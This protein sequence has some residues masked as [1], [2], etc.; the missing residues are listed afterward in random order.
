MPFSTLSGITRGKLIVRLKIIRKKMAHT[1]QNKRLGLVTTT[2]ILALGG[3]SNASANPI[4]I[5]DQ[6]TNGAFTGA[7]LAGWTTTGSANARFA[8]NSINSAPPNGGGNTA[9]DNFFPNAFAVLGENTGFITGAPNQGISSLSQTFILPSI[10]GGPP[11]PTTDCELSTGQRS[12]AMTVPAPT[13]TKTCSQPR[14]TIRCCFRKIP[15]H[16]P[17]ADLRSSVRT[18]R[19]RKT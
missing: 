9:F 5:G 12:M 2:L 8:G 15:I 14:S 18:C 10:V 1:L 4:N 3:I 7:S 17:I 16:C 11:S 13:T 6:I 19:S